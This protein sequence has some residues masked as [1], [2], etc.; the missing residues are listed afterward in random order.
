MFP[1][2]RFADFLFARFGERVAK[3]AVNAGFSCPHRLHGERGCSWCDNRSFSADV[4]NNLSVREQILRGI[5]RSKKRAK[6]FIVYFQAYSNTFAPV[7][8]L[9][10]LYYDA[11]AVDNVVGIAIGTRPDC[12]DEEKIAL[13]AELATKT[14]VQVEYGLQSINDETLAK[15][16]RGHTVNDF[17]QA[18]RLT[19]NK[20]I[21]ICAHLIVGLPQ[22]T[23]NDALRA[24]RFIADCG[25]NAIKI[26]NL[27]LVKNTPLADDYAQNQWTLLSCDDYVRTVVSMLEILPTNI[28]IQRLSATPRNTNDLIAPE[29]CLS[30]NKIHDAIIAEFSRR[31]TTQGVNKE[32]II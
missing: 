1:Y 20:N 19:A 30:P 12:I 25:V 26:H 23:E 29:W 7:E 3:V 4:V 32:K 8:K 11:I 21:N 6:K 13:L 14:F 28:I 31:G 22:D 27:Y 24:A 16:N 5:K 15:N 2:S 17:A 9:R 18:V 10:E